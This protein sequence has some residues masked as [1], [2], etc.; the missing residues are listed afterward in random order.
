[1]HASRPP[2]M[3]AAALKLLL[4]SALSASNASQETYRFTFRAVR[5]SSWA[6]QLQEIRLRDSDGAPL[7]PQS[8]SNPEGQSPRGQGVHNVFDGDE[9][10]AYGKWVDLN[11]ASGQSMILFTISMP[12]SAY[13]FV[14][15]NDN[16][17][18]ACSPHGRPRR[19]H[20]PRA[21]QLC[22]L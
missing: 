3:R 15:A 10:H 1:L 20:A 19:A 11:M 5:S 9:E 6:V 4:T 7:T 13:E 12:V 22:R 14:T 16:P 17:G 2:M 18:R 21:C 8:V